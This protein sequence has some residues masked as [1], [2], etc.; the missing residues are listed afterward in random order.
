MLK[1]VI[2]DMNGVILDDE[3]YQ[4]QSWRVFCDR[5]GL[6][7]SEAEFASRVMGRPESATLADLFDR[8]LSQQ[9]VDELSQERVA[10][11]KE[12]IGASLPMVPG[13]ID[14]LGSLQ[15]AGIPMAVATSSRKPYMN[16]VIDG[17]HIR[18][19]FQVI[20]TAEEVVHGKPDPEIYLKV[21]AR[22]GVTPADCL[23]FEDSRSGVAAAA[24]AG[25]FVVG[26]TTTQTADSL[27]GEKLCIVNFENLTYE[28][29]RELVAEL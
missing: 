26:V 27:V 16:H 10:I 11:T 25:M 4:V 15:K 24:A 8:T 9:E 28:N 14:C 13:L 6:K 17:L 5:R 23:V 29:I 19:Y 7:I 2:F 18:S 22:L 1:A 12:L 3:R 21:A 20:M